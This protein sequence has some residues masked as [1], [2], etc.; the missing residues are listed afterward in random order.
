MRVCNPQWLQASRVTAHPWGREDGVTQP[1]EDAGSQID[2]Q[3]LKHRSL[4]NT[5]RQTAGII[6]SLRLIWQFGEAK[7]RDCAENE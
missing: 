4:G 1:D 3:Q 5:S 2:L 7:E 6:I